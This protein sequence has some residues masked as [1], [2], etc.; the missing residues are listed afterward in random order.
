M[1]G[2]LRSLIAADI[3][4]YIHVVRCYQM[5]NYMH[6]CLRSEAENFGFENNCNVCSAILKP[7]KRD[8]GEQEETEWRWN[9]ITRLCMSFSSPHD[10]SSEPF[11]CFCNLNKKR[12]KPFPIDFAVLFEWTIFQIQIISYENFYLFSHF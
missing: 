3:A 4:H 2:Q 9:R 10:G 11:Y 6:S 1:S 12:F 5:Q 7:S 8:D